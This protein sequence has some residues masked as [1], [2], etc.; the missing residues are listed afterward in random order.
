M[1]ETL[2]SIDPGQATGWSLWTFAD[3][4]ALQRLDYGVIPEGLDGFLRW[5]EARI[6]ALRPSVTV[7][8]LFRPNLGYNAHSKDYEAMLIEGALKAT[9]RALALEVVYQGNDMKALCSDA[10]LKRLGLW[11][12]N[13][14]VEWTDARDV[15]DSQR[16]ALAWA[17]ANGH[18]AT[19]DAFWPAY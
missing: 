5:A 9:A 1:D 15:N 7:F 13:S 8:E 17:K 14:E 18:E 16:H 3:D 10:D 2:L 19:I 6:G 12:E 11:V 4:H